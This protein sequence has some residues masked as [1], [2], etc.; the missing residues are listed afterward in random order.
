MDLSA[1]TPQPLPDPDTREFWDFLAKG[2]LGVCRCQ[3]CGLWMHPPLERCRACNGAVQVEPVTGLGTV[4]SYIVV[5]QPLVPG[6]VPPY[7]VATVE[8]QEQPGLHLV[9]VLN[10]A[11]D[12]VRI[13]ARVQATVVPLPGGA[14]LV[15]EFD[16]V[17]DSAAGGQMAGTKFLVFSNA[18]D[19]RDAEF[20][21]WYD[22]V[23]VAEV[24]AVPGITGAQRY[25]L[26]EFAPEVPAGIEAPAPPPPAHR[27]LAV[28]DVEGAPGQVF[29]EFF[30]RMAD[31][32]LALSDSLDMSTVQLSFWSPRTAAP[33]SQA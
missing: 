5:R 17:N 2:E 12:L 30:G 26:V 15:P 22:D 4:Y 14:F 18:T 3:D 23:H 21:A 7:V 31:G 8:L 28:Y 1:L 13:G 20:N 29:D 9:A 11:P 6:R 25:D 19:G 27:Y 33:G 32:R 10:A 16:L 24:C